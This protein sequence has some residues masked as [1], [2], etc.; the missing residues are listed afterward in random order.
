[1]VS[2]F[3]CPSQQRP[4]SEVEET[5]SMLTFLDASVGA[6]IQPVR[7]R[8]GTGWYLASNGQVQVSVSSG[9]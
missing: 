9:F 1:M 5:D 2:D 4:K 6:T 3:H 8:G 7:Q